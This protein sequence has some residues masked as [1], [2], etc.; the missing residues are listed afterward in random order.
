MKC[1]KHQQGK[2]ENSHELNQPKE[3]QKHQTI[4]RDDR[5]TEDRVT[6]AS[7]RN[8]DSSSSSLSIQ[9]LIHSIIRADKPTATL[10]LCVCVCVSCQRGQNNPQS[11]LDTS[12]VYLL[13]T[14]PTDK[15]IAHLQLPPSLHFVYTAS[16]L[17]GIM[18]A[19]NSVPKIQIIQ[20]VTL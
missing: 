16:I 2:I 1:S 13:T 5:R 3:K 12:C 15:I 18:N 4:Q 19:N 17:T 20:S 11:D 14:G 10:R 8:K 7:R 6:E 9:N